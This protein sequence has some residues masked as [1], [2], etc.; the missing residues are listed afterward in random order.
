M[1]PETQRILRALFEQAKREAG[2]ADGLPRW[3]RIA[4]HNLVILCLLLTLIAA[5]AIYFDP[6]RHYSQLQQWLL[7]G[8]A[9]RQVV[10]GVADTYPKCMNLAGQVVSCSSSEA[11]YGRQH[12]GEQ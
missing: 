6:D 2:F 5:A 10:N 7:D 1:E 8:N 11:F 4:I 12:G 9:E 3:A